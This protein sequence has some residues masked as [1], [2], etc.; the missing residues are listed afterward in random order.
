MKGFVG[1]LG[2]DLP[3]IFPIVAAVILFISTV[4]YA[5]SLVNQ[6]NAE[7][8]LRQAVLGLSYIATEKGLLADIKAFDSL[9]EDKLTKYAVSN[10]LNFIVSV[11]KF[12]QK[13]EFYSETSSATKQYFSPYYLE[14][15][16]NDEWEASQ[17]HTWSYCTNQMKD[18]KLFLMKTQKYLS[19]PLFPVPTEAIVMV[20]PVA[21]R[22]AVEGIPTNGMGLLYVIGWH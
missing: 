11:K 15:F 9:C 12:C 19:S 8:E 7:L 13:V 20:Y 4:L 3:S 2:D 1:P 10:Q 16:S 18:K 5:N 14:T 21:V 6:K 17:G 22:C